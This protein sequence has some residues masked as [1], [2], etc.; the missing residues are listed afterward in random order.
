[1]D[2]GEELDRV[3]VEPIENPVPNEQPVEDEE[4]EAGPD[5]ETELE[6]VPQLA[7]SSGAAA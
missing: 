3:T 2:I 4:V 5:V 1:M 7:H 6:P